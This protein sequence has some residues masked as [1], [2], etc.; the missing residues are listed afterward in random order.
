M[1]KLKT[2]QELCLKDLLTTALTACVLVIFLIKTDNIYLP[3]SLDS[4]L[5]IIFL[6]ILSVGIF[7]L[8]LHTF[9]VPE[10]IIV[11][12]S[13]YLKMSIIFFVFFGFIIPSLTVIKL[14]SLAI[15]LFW[16]I[17]IIYHYLGSVKSYLYSNSKHLQ[18][19]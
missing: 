2:R 15:F 6:A 11:K 7:N 8:N 17:T 16:M 9:L 10:N 14:L 1:E 3:F 5:C 19:R 12:I 4:R 13:N 18:T